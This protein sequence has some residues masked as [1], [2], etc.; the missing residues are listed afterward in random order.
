MVSCYWHVREPGNNIMHAPLGAG[1][2]YRADAF[3]GAWK[4]M[5]E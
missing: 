5:K 3:V 2:V 1:Q 4:T